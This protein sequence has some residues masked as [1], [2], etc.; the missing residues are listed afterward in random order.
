[1]GKEKTTT[2]RA[3]ITRKVQ[4]SESDLILTLLSLEEGRIDAIARGA[5][6]SRKRF[7]AGLS[8]YVLYEGVVAPPRS[9]SLWALREMAVSRSYPSL[10]DNYQKIST[11]AAGTELIRELSPPHQ[12]DEPLFSLLTLFYEALDD[13]QNFSH[14][15]P[16]L[17]YNAL[18]GSG[19]IHHLHECGNCHKAG[20]PGGWA[21]N[22]RD[23]SI[24]CENCAPG[25][26]QL[27]PWESISWLFSQPPHPPSH[28]SIQQLAT[29]L[30]RL[31]TNVLGK[32]LR[33][34]S[35]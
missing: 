19:Y 23:G 13:Q 22:I 24:R 1:M 21:I 20:S 5:R 33:S 32:P 28:G 18:A 27:A 26:A 31:T 3:Y 17:Q 25:G 35:F 4:Y 16:W 6:K 14:L 2:I 30:N 8:Y 11:A 15:L 34:S 29:M 9:G 7:E 10:L 12:E